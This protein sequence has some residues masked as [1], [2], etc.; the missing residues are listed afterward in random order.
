MSAVSRLNRAVPLPEKLFKSFDVEVTCASFG[1][2]RLIIAAEAGSKRSGQI[3]FQQAIAGD[4]LLAGAVSVTGCGIVDDRVPWQVAEVTLHHLA[5][6]QCT[7]YWAS[8]LPLRGPFVVTEEKQLVPQD[9]P[10][11]RGS[12]LV[13]VVPCRFRKSHTVGLV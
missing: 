6:R 3:M 4:L 1:C 2:N 11:D 10:A 7:C 13:L 5:D 8:L 12:K 9:G